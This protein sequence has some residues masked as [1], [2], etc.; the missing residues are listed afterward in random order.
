MIQPGILS[1]VMGKMFGPKIYVS[2]KGTSDNVQF[3]FPRCKSW[4]IMKKWRK[5][6]ENFRIVY[7]SF[8]FNSY[9]EEVIVVHPHI[10][11]QIQLHSTRL[12]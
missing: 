1:G 2:D 9:G 12:G 4:R 7:K 10:H 5:R 11:R 3:K 6:P 8:R